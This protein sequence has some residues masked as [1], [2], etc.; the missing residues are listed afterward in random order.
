MSTIKKDPSGFVHFI[1]GFIFGAVIFIF[2]VVLATLIQAR[3]P[4][5]LCSGGGFS[6]GGGACMPAVTYS[7]LQAARLG[8]AVV[9]PVARISLSLSDRQLQMISGGIMAIL[10]GILFAVPP[11]R[12][13]IEIFL[14]IFALVL[15]LTAFLILMIIITA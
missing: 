6:S 14:I 13:R 8:P 9:I 4:Q 7:L 10:A 11:A 12:P 15:G 1:M 5:S 2:V 3:Q